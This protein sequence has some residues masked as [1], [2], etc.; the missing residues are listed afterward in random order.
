MTRGISPRAQLLTAISEMREELADEPYQDH[1]ADPGAK[2]I[3]AAILLHAEA[4]PARSRSTWPA[5]RFRE[6]AG[7]E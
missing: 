7:H 2:I 6:R 5:R 4:T 1:L 3:A